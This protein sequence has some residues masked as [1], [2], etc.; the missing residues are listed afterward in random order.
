MARRVIVTQETQRIGTGNSP[1]SQESSALG[2]LENELLLL[3]LGS[4]PRR[5]SPRDFN[6]KTGPAL[7]NKVIMVKNGGR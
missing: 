3:L 5:T 2:E 1:I 6:V 7:Q 4:K